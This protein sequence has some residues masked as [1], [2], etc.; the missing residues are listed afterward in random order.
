MMSSMRPTRRVL[1]A[2]AVGLA[3][4]GMLVH[5]LFEVPQLVPFDP[6][7]T[8]P[9]AIYLL[10]GLAW[11]LRPGMVTAWLLGAWTVLNLVGGGILSVLPLPF[12]PFVPEQSVLHYSMH[13]VYTLTQL[14][15]FVLLGRSPR[16]VTSR[17]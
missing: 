14:P 15:L 1:S 2:G 5:D 8:I 13:V 4:A 9:S 7:F 12:L 11:V 17:A 16:G 10:L 3:W 6:Q